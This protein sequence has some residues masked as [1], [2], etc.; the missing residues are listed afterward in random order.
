MRRLSLLS[1]LLLVLVIGSTADAGI[2][3]YDSTFEADGPYKFTWHHKVWS[4][5]SIFCTGGYF[6]QQDIDLDDL[7]YEEPQMT[8]DQGSWSSD[9]GNAQLYY[10]SSEYLG[11]GLHIGHYVVWG[12]NLNGQTL[13]DDLPDYVHTCLSDDDDAEE[14]GGGGAGGE[15]VPE[16]GTLVLMGLGAV[17]AGMAKRRKRNRA[18]T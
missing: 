18:S 1:S 8:W 5:D 7:E 10:M 12:R 3:Q 13:G 9:D 6:E 4:E 15:P 11:N 14:P 16:P 17:A 2:V